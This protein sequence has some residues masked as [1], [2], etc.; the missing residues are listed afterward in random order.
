VSGPISF[1][2]ID[3]REEFFN[4]ILKWTILIFFPVLLA[5]SFFSLTTNPLLVIFFPLFFLLT[6]ISIYWARD[7]ILYTNKAIGFITIIFIWG[8]I[9]LFGNRLFA[10]SQATLLTA[11]LLSAILLPKRYTYG[12][13]SFTLF[14]TILFFAIGSYFLHKVPLSEISSV[15]I[16]YGM[17]SFLFLVFIIFAARKF[18]LAAL[19]RNRDTHKL[20]NKAVNELKEQIREATTANNI[21]RDTLFRTEEK[22]RTLFYSTGNAAFVF[23]NDK[24]KDCNEKA[25]TLLHATKEQLIG[26]SPLGFSPT[27]QPDGQPSKEKA[28][29]IISNVIEGFPQQFEW[30]YKKMNGEVIDVEINLNRVNFEKE[31]YLAI[32]WDISARKKEQQALKESEE[33]YKRLSD[34]T[35]EAIVIA[36]DNTIVDANDQIKNIFG[37][38]AEEFK[39]MNF[40]D[41]IHKDDLEMLTSNIKNNIS[42][43]FIHRGIKKDGSILYLE[44]HTGTIAINNEIHNLIIIHDITSHIEVELSLR[45]SEEK[46]RNIFNSVSDA[47]I[48]ANL[49]G[50]ILEVNQVTL[51]RDGFTR[52]ELLTMNLSNL[53]VIR[54]FNKMSI[55]QQVVEA[56][57]YGIYEI[58]YTNKSGETIPVEINVKQIT[59]NDE[60][61]III[62][63][64]DISERKQ[65]QRKLYKAM[66]ESEER[67]RERYA[68]ELHDGLGP[69]LS[70][71]KIYF[72]TLNVMAD[73]QKRK[74]Y[75]NRAG[76]LLEDALQ[77]IKEIS[78]N[79]SPHV[80]R[81]YGLPQ[82][83][84]SFTAKLT[85]ITDTKILINSNLEERLPEIIEFTLYRT[86]IELINNSMKYSKAKLIRLALMQN[87]NNLAIDFSD[88]GI[89]FD[90]AQLKQQ[91]TGFGLLNLEHRIQEI[92]GDYTF[93]SNSGEGVEV[94]ITINNTVE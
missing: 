84:R 45:R 85:G 61:A 69:L 75:V 37:Y 67:E 72:Y 53:I 62:V 51:Q 40:E 82:A 26:S 33:R 55:Y 25:L 15:N 7:K 11:I 4:Y 88:N 14:S 28:R 9:Q 49:K 79:L 43:P 46:F 8:V 92:G 78:N 39:K 30:Q 34:S 38:S 94:N 29:R 41:F 5:I 16:F 52:D 31:M 32:F 19:I 74:Q 3:N 65:L 13:F 90:Y 18:L 56:Q 44:M 6:S 73:G 42:M 80:L 59:Y 10:S 35:F 77:S 64:R 22:F 54:D 47:I 91:V 20:H 86:L 58:E 60:D 63:S 66:I 81:N 89:G 68:K 23:Q 57:G 12:A 83:L 2:Q 48:I 71:C 76:E 21:L 70:T 87:A 1:K 27:F 93:R 17:H 36:K 24:I 50:E